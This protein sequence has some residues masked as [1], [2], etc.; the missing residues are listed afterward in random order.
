VENIQL[1]ER[2]RG[3]ALE[4]KQIFSGFLPETLCKQEDFFIILDAAV[5]LRNDMT[6][7][8]AI[9][10][11]YWISTDNKIDLDSGFYKFWEWH[12]SPF[13]IC[14][15]PG[16]SQSVKLHDGS[17]KEICVRPAKLELDW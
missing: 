7:E 15:F 9:Y 2:K 16:F 11:C 8:L 17:I 12:E 3:L 1:L 13:P 6:K 10:S 4:L 5:D 14:L